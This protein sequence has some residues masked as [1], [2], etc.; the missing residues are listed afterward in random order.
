MVHGDGGDLLPGGD[1]RRGGD[2]RALG[3]HDGAGVDQGAGEVAVSEARWRR[4]LRFWKRDV[5]GDVDDEL[6]F[7][8]EERRAQFEEAGLKRDEADAVAERR[9]GD[10][11]AVRQALVDIDKRIAQRFELGE[12]LN[13]CW[14]DLR[15]SVRSLRRQ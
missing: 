11:F 2:E 1:E 10:R 14:A 8:F 13:A 7:H 6:R 15:W 4:Y 9:F 5:A 3:R 12:T